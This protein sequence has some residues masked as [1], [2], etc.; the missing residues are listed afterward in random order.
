MIDRLAGRARHVAVA[1]HD[2]ALGREAIK[3]LKAAGTSCEVEVLL[4]MPAGPLLAWAKQNGVKVRVY[5]P[6]GCGFIANAAGVLRRN[7]R[8]MLAIAKAQF[9]QF[10]ALF[11]SRG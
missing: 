7:P 8:L 2:F 11:S 9:D 6:Y 10:A 3:R 5:V 1:T 4:G